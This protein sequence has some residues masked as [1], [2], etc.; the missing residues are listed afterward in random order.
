MLGKQAFP[1]IRQ[2]NEM[3]PGF[4]GRTNP[5]AARACQ[6]SS[7]NACSRATKLPNSIGLVQ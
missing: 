1:D 4:E 2:T 5:G 6:P 7:S 3:P